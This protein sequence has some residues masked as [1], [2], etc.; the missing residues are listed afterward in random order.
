MSDSSS[1]PICDGDSAAFRIDGGPRVGSSTGVPRFRTPA[2]T[3]SKGFWR[4][5]ARVPG[6]DFEFAKNITFNANVNR[7]MERFGGIDF[8]QDPIPVVHYGQHEPTLGLRLGPQHR[9]PDLLRRGQPVS[10]PRYRVER[11]HQPPP[12]PRLHSDI[13]INA[14]RSRTLGTTTRWCSTSRSTAP[15][16]PISSRTGSCSATLASTTA[17]TRRSIRTSC[18]RIASMPNG[19]L[20]G[21]RRSLSAGGSDR[22][23]PRRRWYR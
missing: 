20:R 15:R 1:E 22:T 13:N 12:F 7:D 17:S 16:P 10:W 18:P 14:N 9:R 11:V 21:L 5:R 4:M 19:L 3:T 23:R 2:A 6:L 8:L